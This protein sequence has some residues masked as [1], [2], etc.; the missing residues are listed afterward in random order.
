MP[1]TAL[2]AT[3]T[4][5]T[6]DL[7]DVTLPADVARGLA[8]LYGTDEPIRDA[9]AWTDANRTAIRDTQ[10]R[11]PTVEDLCTTPDGAH[12]F[13]PRNGDDERQDYVCVLDP[14]AY[15]FL[16]D[17][18]GTITSRTPVRGEEIEVDVSEDG[19]AVSHPDAVISLGVSDHA[20]PDA[21]VTLETVYR[22]VC[23]FVHLF[24]D[25]DEYETWAADA[26]A[27]TTSVPVATGVGLATGLA[28]AL[29]G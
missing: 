22:Q 6:I 14:L 2:D 26:D 13:A 16:A 24:A 9:A 11:T 23:G 8:A 25:E 1:D 28:D 27:A 17:V 3:R 29:F 21:P 10:G 7:A 18:P 12:T 20:D 5:P 4:G 19:V 15:P